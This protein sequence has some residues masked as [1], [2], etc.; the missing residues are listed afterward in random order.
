MKIKK[1]IT[2]NENEEMLS[3]QAKYNLLRKELGLV[4]KVWWPWDKAVGEEKI[5][6]EGRLKEALKKCNI[7]SSDNKA[8]KF[9]NK[10][11]WEKLYYEEEGNKHLKIVSSSY[12]DSYTIWHIN[13]NS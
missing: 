10:N 4:K 7:V 8:K 5:V 12:K 6:T 1:F 9:I 3:K 2:T 13:K 11:L